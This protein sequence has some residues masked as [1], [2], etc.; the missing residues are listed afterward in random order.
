M[1]TIEAAE[2]TT[3]SRAAVWALLADA[4][5]W[6]RWGSWS[7]VE[8]EGDGR[9]GP[10]AIRVLHRAPFRTRERITEWAPEERLGY[11][12][13][14]G[15]RVDGYRS[16][17]ALEDAPEG[18]GTVIRWRSTYQRAG[19]FTAAILRLSVRDACKRL[20]KAA[21]AEAAAQRSPS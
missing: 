21:S 17:V 14:G 5:S 3:A 15:M 4:S 20:A 19:P 1:R 13:L 8:V 2:R 12:V 11:E 6:A 9:Q 18:G 16:T 7:K 10:G